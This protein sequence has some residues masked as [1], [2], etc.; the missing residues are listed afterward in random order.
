[1]KVRVKWTKTGVLKF[2][3]HLDVQRYF[4]KALM[5][6]ELPVS[7][8]KGMSPHQI[9]SFAAPLGLGMTSEGEYA[10]ISFDWS[11]SSEEMLKRIN[12][13]MNEGISVLEFKEIDEKEKNCMAVTEAADYLVTFREG[14]YYKDAFLKRT[15]PFYLQ[16]KIPVIKKTKRSEK[17]VDIAP[18]ILDIREYESEPLIPGLPLKQEGIFMK[19]VTGSAENL[20]PQLVMEAFCK[21]LGYDYDNKCVFIPNNEIRAEYVN[22]VSVSEWGEVSRALKNSADILNAIWQRREQRVADGIKEAHFETSHIQ[23]NDE[24]ALSYTIS[25]A[26]YAAR[27]FYTVYRE[28]PGGKG[29]ADMVYIPK[30]KFSDKP[31]LV[32][33]LKWDKDAR[34][35]IEQIK[36]KEYCKSLDEYRGNILLVGINYSLKT[37]EHECIIEEYTK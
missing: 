33:E 9:M 20:K 25:L 10:D 12:A 21:Y 17:E 37:K 27:N 11:Y 18:L 35:A 26:L 7:F 4:Q 31:A 29:F 13:V 1:M 16:E 14:Y 32:V 36:N 19:L 8:S 5:R 3:G 34:G 22:A 28:F 15:Q 23:Y 30:K 6:A 24:N 2:I